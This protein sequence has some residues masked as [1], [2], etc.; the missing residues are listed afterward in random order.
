MLSDSLFFFTKVDLIVIFMPA[1]AINRNFPHTV[2]ITGTSAKKANNFLSYI[3]SRDTDDCSY[4][5]NK[6]MSEDNDLFKLTQFAVD[7]IAPRQKVKRF[8]SFLL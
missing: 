3:F 8:L 2:S 1:G 4:Y 7:A 6:L 5:R